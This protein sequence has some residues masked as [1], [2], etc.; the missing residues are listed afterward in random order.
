[1]KN[2]LRS[3]AL[4]FAVLLL[5]SYGMLY[6]AQKFYDPV[7]AE[8]YDFYSYYK[9][10]QAPL[11]FT[12]ANAPFVYRQFSALA[13]HAIFAAG[14]YYP[15]ETAF[16]DPQIDP[17]LFFAALAANYLGLVMAATFAGAVAERETGGFAFPLLAG[18]LCLLSFFSQSL[19]LTGLTEGM[20]WFFFGAAYFLYV[21]EKR[22]TL[23]L[24]LAVSIFQREMIPV[25]F[26]LIAAFSLL[27]RSGDKAYNRF[28]LSASILCF[29]AY[30]LIRSY[31]IAAPGFES[32]LSLRFLVANLVSP[33]ISLGTNLFQGFL[34]QNLL[35]IALAFGAA[36]WVRTYVIPK[37]LIVLT[38]TLLAV[39][40]IV[41]A[42][43][44]NGGIGRISG[45]LSPALAAFAA[46]SLYRY[47]RL[48]A[49]G[50]AA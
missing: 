23:A 10:Y 24:V 38:L 22:W 43:A 13:T 33:S 29:G 18:L 27:V 3:F 11:D 8:H 35:F 4:R 5:A 34:S 30:V 26:A 46:I 25:V 17:R 6:A 47:E 48:G 42:E 31:L 20:T 40:I 28:V 36:L 44:I 49:R 45:M 12:A 41:F 50:Q 32:Q 9:M 19:V 16:S 37:P 14:I 7:Q 15:N 2:G 1:M 39:A 21:L